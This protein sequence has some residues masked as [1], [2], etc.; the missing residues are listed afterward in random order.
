M[1]FRLLA[2]GRRSEL[3]AIRHLRSLGYRVLTSRYRTATGEVDVIAWDGPILAF[4]EV[5]SRQNSDPPE[6]SV[7]FTKR[8]RIIRAAHHYMSR[9]RLHDSPY[10]FDIVAV[11]VLPGS[12]PQFRLLRDAFRVDDFS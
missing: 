8:R 7:G 6:D 12:K 11:T 2:F 1:L 5:K 3:L 10:R 4:I 9:Y